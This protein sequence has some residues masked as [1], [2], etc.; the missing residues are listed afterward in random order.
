MQAND[1]VSR[2]MAGQIV[3]TS[4]GDLNWKITGEAILGAEMTFGTCRINPGEAIHL[5][6]PGDAISI[7]RKVSHWA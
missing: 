1:P 2:K 5:L 7:P 4:W 3:P 6:E